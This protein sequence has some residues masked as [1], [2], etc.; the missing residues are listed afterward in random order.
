VDDALS[1]HDERPA[2]ASPHADPEGDQSSD[3]PG[4]QDY[5]KRSEIRTCGVRYVEAGAPCG[6]EKSLEGPSYP[7]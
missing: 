1:L 5:V 2:G 6:A 3:V 4:R 7:A